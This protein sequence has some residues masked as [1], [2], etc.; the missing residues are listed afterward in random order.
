MSGVWK[1]VD[2]L[3]WDIDGGK[4][5]IDR[6]NGE[7]FIPVEPIKPEPVLNEPSYLILC[8]PPLQENRSAAQ[9]SDEEGGSS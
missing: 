4:E 9:V 3:S 5:E 7:G 6:L 2:K 8:E 1:K